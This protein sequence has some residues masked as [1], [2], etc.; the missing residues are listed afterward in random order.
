MLCSYIETFLQVT[1]SLNVTAIGDITVVVYH[2]RY[3]L[4][5]PTGIKILQY[6]FHSGFLSSDTVTITCSK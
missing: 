5:R 2:A 1:L 6:Q 3:V 4:G